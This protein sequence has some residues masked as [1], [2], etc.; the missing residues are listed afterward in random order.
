MASEQPQEGWT[1]YL[2]S[3]ASIYRLT[4]ETEKPGSKFV[5]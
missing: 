3:I 5:P 1:V 4:V 2:D